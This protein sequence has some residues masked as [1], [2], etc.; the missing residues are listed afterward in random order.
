MAVWRRLSAVF[1]LGMGG[2]HLFLVLTG[3]GGL[4]GVLFV[5]NAVG[6][7]ALAVAVIVVR[8]QRLGLASGLGLLFVLGTLLALLIALSPVSL[9]GMRSS[10]GYRLAP[11][12]IVVESVGVVVL[13]VTTVLALR[14]RA[15]GVR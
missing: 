15:G 10:L 13:A 9:F 12:S 8:Q 4:L 2:I 6:A 7:V 3:T 11:T 5:V 1:L 14:K